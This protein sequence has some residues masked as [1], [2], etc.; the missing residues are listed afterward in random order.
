MFQKAPNDSSSRAMA[1]CASAVEPRKT[2][3]S[4]TSFPILAAVAAARLISNCSVKGATGVNRTV[5]IAKY[6]T[7]WWVLAAAME[8]PPESPPLLRCNVREEQKRVRDA[9]IELPNLTD[10]ATC[11]EA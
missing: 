3:S 9:R 1:V 5:V 6:T 11:I 10:D 2:W 7:G 4:I 8:L